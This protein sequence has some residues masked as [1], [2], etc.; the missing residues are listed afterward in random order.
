MFPA[1]FDYIT[2]LLQ[3]LVERGQGYARDEESMKSKWVAE[4]LKL[5][6]DSQGGSQNK[7]SVSSTSNTLK[8][9]NGSRKGAVSDA[10]GSGDDD[11]E[12]DDSGDGRESVKV[13]VAEKKFSGGFSLEQCVAAVREKAREREEAAQNRMPDI[14]AGANGGMYSCYVL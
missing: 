12:G 11:L 9:E 10:V 7:Q 6:K 8:E 3:M 13:E 2:H 4:C 5:F 14:S 1:P